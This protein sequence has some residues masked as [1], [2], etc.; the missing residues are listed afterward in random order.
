MVLLIPYHSSLCQHLRVFKE[1]TFITIALDTSW[2]WNVVSLDLVILVRFL[3]IEQV[4]GQR[5][6]RLSGKAITITV[7]VAC[8]GCFMDAITAMSG[9]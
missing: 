1:E 7:V 6:S 8:A 2:M 9:S 5:L 4:D 3:G